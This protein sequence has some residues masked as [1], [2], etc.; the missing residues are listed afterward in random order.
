MTNKNDRCDKFDINE[1]SVYKPCVP[2]YLLLDDTHECANHAGGKFTPAPQAS[3]AATVMFNPEC[4]CCTYHTG[5][6]CN[7]QHESHGDRRTTERE[8]CGYQL[9]PRISGRCKTVEEELC[10]RPESSIMH[11]QNT[12][13]YHEFQPTETEVTG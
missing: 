2:F 11:N 3:P 5:E 1:H 13:M 7:C 9:R 6:N 4:S 12:V 8:R 10:D